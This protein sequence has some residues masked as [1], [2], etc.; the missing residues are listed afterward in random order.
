MAFIDLSKAFDTVNREIM[1]RVLDEFGVPPKILSIVRQ[2]HDGIQARV[3][4]GSFLSESFLVA[5]GVKQ[6]CVLAPV[7]FN[8]Y[9]AAINIITYNVINGYKGLAVEYRLDGILFN[10]RHLQ[11]HTKMTVTEVAQIQYADDLVLLVNSPINLQNSLN[12]IISAYETMGLKV[13]SSKGKVIVQNN[14][15]IQ[16]NPAFYI[17]NEEIEA[18]DSFPYLGSILS[19]S[20][21]EYV[22]I[23]AR[24]NKA[25]E[26]YGRLFQ[27]VF[28]I[29]DLKTTT[30]VAVYRAVCVHDAIYERRNTSSLESA[31][32]KLHLK[33]VVIKMTNN[34]LPKQILHGQ[35]HQDSRP[36]GGQKKRFKDQYK[37]LLKGS[38]LQPSI[39]ETFASDKVI[40]IY[41]SA[42][43]RQSNPE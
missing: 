10:L 2:L 24:I 23:N 42:E 6:G 37:K 1:C 26:A 31:F 22:D 20:S 17:H 36:P 32:A 30:R 9:V 8:L 39:L 28:T 38:H 35:L 34:K 41:C 40:W 19:C 18:M 15:N 13:N 12:L 43:W 25:S 5:T 21:L 33:W 4:V 3:L 7:L 14:N 27:R 29:R 11:A 16:I